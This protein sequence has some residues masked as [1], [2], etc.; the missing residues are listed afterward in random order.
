M[1]ER[2]ASRRLPRRGFVGAAAVLLIVLLVA[3]QILLPRIAV[4]RLRSRL[5]RHGQVLSVA[6]SAFP[7]IELLWGQAGSVTVRMRSYSDRL[8]GQ[9]PAGD[10]GAGA[11]GPASDPQHRLANVLA[12][13]ANTGSL[14]ARVGTFQSGRLTLDDVVLTKHGDELTASALLTDAHLQAALPTAFSLQPLRSP[15]GQLLFR[16]SVSVAGAHLS[17][18]ARL[19]AHDGALVVEPDLAGLFPSFLSLTIFRDP[20]VS[21]QSVGVRPVAG[22]W[23]MSARGRLTGA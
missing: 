23:Q 11:G 9:A 4:D 5:S 14:D 8:A 19:R 1:N 13:T 16:G 21:V 15:A 7:A 6:V 20:R 12:G 3:A 22:G 10:G 18:T 17:V 2:A